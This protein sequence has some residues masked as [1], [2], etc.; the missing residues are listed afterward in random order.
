[1]GN[2]SLPDQILEG[3]TMVYKQK[4]VY[5]LRRPGKSAGISATVGWQGKDQF[6]CFTS[7]T[8]FEQN[9]PYDKFGAYAALY[10][11]GDIPAAAI[12]LAKLG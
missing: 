4:G 11:G 6:Y 9:H 5:Y 2:D 12:A 7:S 10:H 3:W 1:M 8:E